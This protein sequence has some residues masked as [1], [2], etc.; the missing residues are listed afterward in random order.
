MAGLSGG[1]GGGV[2]DHANL[3]NVTASQHHPRPTGVEIRG[4]N[5]SSSDGTRTTNGSV[6]ANPTLNLNSDEIAIV[7]GYDVSASLDPTG[8]CGGADD[9]QLTVWTETQGEQLT[10]GSSTD[11]CTNSISRSASTLQ[12]LN[13]NWRN[14]A[15]VEAYAYASISGYE[16]D[17]DAYA[18][19]QGFVIGMNG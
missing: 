15:T 6:T 3:T 13:N 14:G 18:Q 1:G 11:T 4:F 10:Y 9:A 5:I 17:I 2:E 12:N 7:T 8:T 16:Y 19:I